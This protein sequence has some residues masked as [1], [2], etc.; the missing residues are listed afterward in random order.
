MGMFHLS[1]SGVSPSPAHRER[2]SEDEGIPT[3]D[4]THP[5]DMTVYDERASDRRNP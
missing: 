1:W 3:L 4:E 5:Y 2:V